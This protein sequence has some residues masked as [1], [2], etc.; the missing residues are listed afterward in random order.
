MIESLRSASQSAP[1]RLARRGGRERGG[2]ERDGELDAA[3][4]GHG[5]GHGH[6][7][8]LVSIDAIP[9]ATAGEV[10]CVETAR[11]ACDPQASDPQVCDP[12]V[13]IQLGVVVGDHFG[14]R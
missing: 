5:H 9:D 11:Q 10:T 3:S 8:P 2:R 6:P 14:D 12:E 13:V 4:V 7:L 1:V